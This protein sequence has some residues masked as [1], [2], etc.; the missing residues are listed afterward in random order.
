[1]YF[2]ETEA[3]QVFK[4][5]NEPRVGTRAVYTVVKSTEVCS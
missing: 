2:E 1:M 3:K 4:T 5:T